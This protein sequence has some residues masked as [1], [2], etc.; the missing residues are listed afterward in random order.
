MAKPEKLTVE[1]NSSLSREFSLFAPALLIGSLLSN[2][3]H[4]R[5]PSTTVGTFPKNKTTIH[6]FF[7][8]KA[9]ETG[10]KILYQIPA[11]F[12]QGKS[13]KTRGLRHNPPFF[14]LQH[15]VLDPASKTFL[16]E[17]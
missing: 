4:R 12:Q 17:G 1:G 6:L 2:T 8:L 13:R 7:L 3:S 14:A 5:Q 15:D 11:G 9:K 16:F 10:A